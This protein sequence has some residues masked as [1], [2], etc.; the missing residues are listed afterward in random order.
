MVTVQSR[1]REIL[2][3][4][5]NFWSMTTSQV[6][7]IAALSMILLMSACGSG[8]RD[9]SSSE[10]TSTPRIT[11]T[12]SAPA[13]PAY[14]TGRVTTGRKPCG[15]VGAAGRV[16]VS[17]Y[18]DNTLVWIDPVTLAVSE[19]IQ[20]GSQPCGLA[21]GAGSIWVENYGSDDV[22]RVDATTSAVQA[23]IAVGRSPYDVTF[24]DGAAWVTDYASGTISRLDPVTNTRSAVIDVGGTPIGIAHTPGAVWVPIG[25]DDVVRID[26]ATNTVVATVRT[27]SGA[28][29]TAYDDT[30]VWVANGND[31]TVSK[32][33][34]ATNIV[35]ATVEVGGKPL[36]G[37][38]VD[39]TVWIPTKEGL[40]YPID[41]GNDEI[42]TGVD[43]TSA[44]PFVIAGLDGVVWAVDF[45][46]TDVVRID[47]AALP[48]G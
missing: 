6:R 38:V 12:T 27:G 14:V 8:A 37:D 18:G 25:S 28:G 4:G 36:D 47:P 31:G 16:W 7:V 21:Y 10:P 11:Q 30:A 15:V 42:G 46:G 44:N 33:D 41:A 22:T 43:A 2:Q 34:P 5:T 3:D 26:T 48:V 23:T 17:N 39:G 1:M 9:D 45:L 29:W 13:D 35:V 32:I 24:A 19:P 40:L 20:V